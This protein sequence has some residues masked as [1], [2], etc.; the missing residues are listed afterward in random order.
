V[1]LGV[2]GPLLV[3]RDDGTPAAVPSALRQLLLTV[4]AAAG[5][6]LTAEEL[7]DRLWPDRIPDDPRAAL[8]SHVSRLRR[9]LGP[10]A[11]WLVTTGSGYRLECPPE[12]VDAAR[13]ERLLAAARG[14]DG[15]P[16]AV[17]DLLDTALGLWRGPAYGEF[18]DHPALAPAAAR[19]EELRIEATELRAEALLDLGRPAEAASAMRRLTAD[20]PFRERPVALVMRALAQ[21]GRHAEALAAYRGF[22]RLLADELG[23]DPSRELRAVEAGVLG[24]EEPAR[25]LVPTVGV[26]GDSFVGRDAE[27]ARCAGLLDRHRSVTLVGAGGVGKTRLAVHVAAEIAGRYPDGVYLCELASVT[28]PHA[29]PQAVASALHVEHRADRSVLDRIVEFLRARRALLV[30]DNCEHVLAAAAAVVTAVLRGTPGTAVLAT[31]RERLG[32]AGE[33]RVPVGPLGV[34]AWDDPGAP[35]RCCS[36]T[37]CGPSAPTSRS[38]PVTPRPSPSC[39]DDSTGSRW[40]SSSPRPG[41]CPAPPRRS[42][43]RS[44]GGSTP[45]PTRAARWRGTAPCTRSSTGP[46]SC[47]ARRSATSSRG[48]RSSPAGG[49][50]RLPL[51]SPVPDPRC[52][53]SW[54]SARS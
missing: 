16:A 8:Q 1:T 7:A 3:V 28:D 2:L 30:L 49:Q 52:S 24:H 46:S 15:G 4:L 40:R 38:V 21:D 17:C 18:A 23:V 20:H 10:A 29:V 19:L 12:R 33:H 26:P 47:W 35:P 36:P 11:A 37:G 6:A 9:Q 54:S 14:R 31:S 22:R 43:P 13:F 42:S 27:L 41:P 44:A 25:R 50:Q 45:S 53:P 34:P 5:R 32:V 48:S 39:A 51:T